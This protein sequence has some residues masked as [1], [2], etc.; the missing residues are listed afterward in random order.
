MAGRMIDLDQITRLTGGRLGT[1]DV[2]CPLC[3]PE[4]PTVSKRQRKVLRVWSLAPGFTTFYCVR[5][6]EKGYLRDGSVSAPDTD[7][8][9]R[10]RAEIA[11][12]QRTASAEQ[13]RKA[14][15]LWSR[16]Q[17]IAGTPG[18]TYLREARGY[19]GPLPATLGYLPPRG[20]HLP[21]MIAAFGLAAE[22]EPGL[23]QI[24]DGAVRGVHITRLRADGFGK[25]DIGPEKIMV[26][27]SAGFPIVLAP[28]ND[29]LGLAITEGIEDGL[30][31]HAATGLGAWVA[32]SA[33][34]MP[35]L[36]NT[37]PY[38]IECV[39]VIVDDD[40]SGR[41]NAAELAARVEPRGV[42]VRLVTPARGVAT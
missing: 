4:R 33:S 24:D 21:A 9:A 5:C 15:W 13:L 34:R 14:R 6:D 30:S 27:H 22:P 12:R 37:I 38:Y 28:A 26:G 20:E 25:A 39:T 41:R 40:D 35:A 11:V 1:F 3:G 8:M 10:I 36:A 29:L 16:R 2:S 23:L 31:A 7:A 17:E 32:G 19:R 18:E 42:E